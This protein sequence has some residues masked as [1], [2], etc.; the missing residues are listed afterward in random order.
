LN[1]YLGPLAK[2]EKARSA[3]QQKGSSYE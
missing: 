2:D 3:S 1:E